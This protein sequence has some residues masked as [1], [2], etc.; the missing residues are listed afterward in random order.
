MLLPHN[1]HRKWVCSLY[2]QCLKMTRDWTHEYVEYRRLAVAIRAQFDE[3][4]GFK[5]E[6]EIT[7]FM[8]SIEYILYKYI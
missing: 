2:K 1:E 5:E 6:R 8:R 4:K 3:A 7:L